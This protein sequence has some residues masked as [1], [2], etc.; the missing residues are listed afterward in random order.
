ML[1][2]D[3]KQEIYAV[4]SE[5]CEKFKSMGYAV[6]SKIFFCDSNLM[7][8]T[9]FQK[10]SLMIFGTVNIGT[11]ELED[12]EYCRFAICAEIRTAL[13]DDEKLQKS[14]EEYKSEIES[15]EAELANATSVKDKLIEISERQQREGEESL[16]EFNRE[17]RS[18]KLK[19]YLA[20]GAL[21]IIA[22]LL[23]FS[24]LLFK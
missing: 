14:I 18:V 4:I 15:F 6:T 19:L 7:E 17:M 9:E 23:L 24:N 3:A 2:D 5:T 8:T 12:D 22:L 21:A 13:V 20:L 1:L 11:E 16:T 10:N